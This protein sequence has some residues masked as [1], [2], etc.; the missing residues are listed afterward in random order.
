MIK[1]TSL[2][3]YLYD[4]KYYLGVIDTE[5]PPTESFKPGSKRTGR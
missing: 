1:E 2:S 4:L 3:Q 5:T